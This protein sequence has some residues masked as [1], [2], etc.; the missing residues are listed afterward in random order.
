[1]GMSLNFE[2]I[3]PSMTLIHCQT[4]DLTYLKFFQHKF[5]KCYSKSDTFSMDGA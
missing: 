3:F 1:M 4:S 5:W 2:H